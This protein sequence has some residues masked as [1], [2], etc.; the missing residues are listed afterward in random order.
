MTKSGRTFFYASAPI[1]GG[2]IVL[3]RALICQ[4]DAPLAH[5]TYSLRLSIDICFVVSVVSPC[6]VPMRCPHAVSPCGVPVRLQTCSP[7][8]APTRGAAVASRPSPLL[9]RALGRWGYSGPPSPFRPKWG[10]TPRPRPLGAL[11]PCS[12]V[13]SPPPPTLAG[14]ARRVP[15]ASGSPLS[16]GESGRG[17]RPVLFCLG[18]RPRINALLAKKQ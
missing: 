7:P 9:S 18:L 2:A 15:P 16:S 5:R 10:A 6:G 8:C 11:P 1:R 17:L 14:S 13:A 4:A 3:W 12:S